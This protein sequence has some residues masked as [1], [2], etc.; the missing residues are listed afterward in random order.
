VATIDVTGTTVDE[1]TRTGAGARRRSL[2]SWIEALWSQALLWLERRDWDEG[3]TLMVFG[4]V[5]GLITGLTVVGFYRMIDLANLIVIRFPEAHLATAVHALYQPAL[6]AIGLWGAWF[7]VRRS[8]IPEGQNV[9]DVQLAV[10]KRDGRI[11]SAPVVA[12]TVASA[13]TLGS[14]GSAGSEGP[15]AVLGATV[16]SALGKRL[17]FQP[18]HLKILVGCGAAAGIAGAF[19]APFAGAFFALEEVLGSF[20]VGAF[21]P[22]VIASVVGA[23]TVRPLMGDEQIFHVPSL[24]D[25]HPARSALLY[26]ILGLICGMVSA[27]YSRAYLAAPGWS[28]RIPG[29]E[30]VRPLVGGAAVGLIVLLTGGLLAGNGH[31]ALPQHLFGELAWYVLI[32]VALAKIAA[33]VI[34]LGFGGSGGVFTPTLV[35]GAALGGGLGALGEQVVPGHIVHAGAWALVGMAGMVAGAT[36]APLT[37]IFIVFEMTDDYSF[38][39]PIMIVA[40]VAYTTAKRFAPHGLYD[41]WLAAKG[42][43]IAH[44]VDQSVMDSLHVRDALDD[45]VLPV[46]PDATIDRLV[47]AAA[48]TRH[49]VI[50]VVEENGALV[51][52]ISHHTLREALIGRG[53]LASVLVA[54]DLVEAADPLR[55]GQTL[56]ESLAAMNARGLD[57]LPVV[58]APAAGEDAPRFAG[59]LSRA[60]ILE[61]YE[62]ALTSAV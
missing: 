39:V 34:T 47:S 36:R 3:A 60:V 62:R 14:G 4:V 45:D 27:L 54:E 41:G 25:P 42:E 2:A 23:L 1:P 19:N 58:R 26:P 20:S 43:H 29:P 44:G 10:A 48:A 9:P 35:I 53:D 13:L 57:A 12:R 59:L 11:R 56:R 30:W 61:A 17:R 51:G 16:G 38:V 55:L 15:V 5:I 18:R 31:L 40:V 37:A 52:V 49:G 21:S 46:G 22:V 7:V 6:T 50:A 32:G 28:A 24:T 8:G 33:T